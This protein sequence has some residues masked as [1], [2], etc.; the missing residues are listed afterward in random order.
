[1][2]KIPLYLYDSAVAREKGVLRVEY[3]MQ[4]GSTKSGFAVSTHVTPRPEDAAW[5]DVVNVGEVKRYIRTM[6]PEPR[7]PVCGA[8]AREPR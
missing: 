4:D 1:M 5:P 3:E 8:P 6:Y 2:P 7:C